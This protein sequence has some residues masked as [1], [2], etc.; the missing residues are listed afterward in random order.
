MLR[1]IE[2]EYLSAIPLALSKVPKDRKLYAALVPC[3]GDT[4]PTD[5][6]IVF[7][8][9]LW[10][11]DMANA[12]RI[13][14]MAKSKSELFRLSFDWGENFDRDPIQ[15][16][17]TRLLQNLKRWYRYQAAYED[18]Q[19]LVDLIGTS[20]AKVCRTSNK[21]GWS[22]S[23]FA[24]TFVVYTD[25]CT[26]SYSNVGLDECVL[27]NWKSHMERKF[28]ISIRSLTSRPASDG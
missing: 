6:K 20:I 14:T 13:E 28:E 23:R 18:D 15:L 19:G 25:N 24:K 22:G 26:D 12:K 1:A 27:P 21:R 7:G 9:T 3:F 16:D 11:L 17:S 2:K 5:D 10:T 4:F 8:M